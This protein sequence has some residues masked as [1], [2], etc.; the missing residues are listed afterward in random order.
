MI[1]PTIFLSH[2]C[3]K[4]IIVGQRGPETSHEATTTAQAGAGG[5]ILAVEVGV[6]QWWK[7]GAQGTDSGSELIDL[8]D[9]LDVGREG[10]GE[11]S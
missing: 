10:V 6:A 3:G 9:G 8:A 4:F 7:W 5:S 11:T 1:K 2:L